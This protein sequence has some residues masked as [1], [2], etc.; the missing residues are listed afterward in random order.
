M[1]AQNLPGLSVAVGAG[2]EMVWAEGFG[3]ADI[4]TQAPATPDTRFRIGTASAA[5]TSAA[6]G[7]LLE[8]GSL[9]LD[10]E[11]QTHVPRFPRKQ[12]PVTL[13]QLMAHTSGLGSD[14]GDDGP[15]FRQR[16]EQPVQALPHFADDALLFEPGTQYRH[17]NYGWILVSAAIE[18]AAAQPFLA[19][20]RERIFQP[21]GMTNTDAESA[22]RENPERVG[23]PAE[24]APIF[25]L[26]RDLILEPIGLGGAGGKPTTDPATVYSP[27]F[28]YDPQVRYGLHVMR[29]HNL[30]CYA[31][32]M[33]FFSTPSDLVRFGLALENGELLQPATVE[34]LQTSQQ[35]AS[36]QETGHGLG[37]DLDAQTAGLDGELLSRNVASLKMFPEADLVVA[38]T[39]NLSD[40][41]TSTLAVQIAEAFAQPRGR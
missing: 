7:L 32:S 38:I 27:G 23:E 8:Q 29:P 17:S 2:G 26:I 18:A 14:A 35:L 12:A 37:W 4:A 15:L 3:W 9:T 13:R 34:L 36:G 11:I 31:G 10:D 1:A 20:M 39:A 22:A 5:L 40:A 33:A 28:G 41:D 16:C 24:D 21:L 6:V 19:V 25:T 30:S